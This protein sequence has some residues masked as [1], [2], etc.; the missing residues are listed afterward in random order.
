MIVLSPRRGKAA[1]RQDSI[2]TTEQRLSP[3]FSSSS[4]SSPYVLPN[5]LWVQAIS[6]S[7]VW[8]S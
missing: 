8:A 2:T 3:A 6:D 5:W 7:Q 4:P 1:R